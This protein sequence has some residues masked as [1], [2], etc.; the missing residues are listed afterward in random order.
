VPLPTNS[1]APPFDTVTPFTVAPDSTTSVPPLP[2]LV[3]LRKPPFATCSVAP[4]ETVQPLPAPVTVQ[5]PPTTP[6]VVK[7]LYCVPIEL[8]SNVSEPVPPS[9]KVFVPEALTVPLMV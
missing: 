3:L 7:P 5:I 9:W 8:R 1:S 6:K 4:L 2:T